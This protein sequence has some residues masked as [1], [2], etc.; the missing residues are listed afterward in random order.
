MKNFGWLGF[1]ENGRERERSHTGE[2]GRP[3]YRELNFIERYS[4]ITSLSLR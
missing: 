3:R 1:G 4:K 2:E